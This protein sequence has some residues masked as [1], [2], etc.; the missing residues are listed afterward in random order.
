MDHPRAIPQKQPGMYAV[1][2][3]PIGGILPVDKP[4]QLYELLKDVPG[5]EIRIAPHETLYVINLTAAEAERV[6]A[7][8]EDG[9]S[10]EFECSVACI[11]AATCQQGVRGTWQ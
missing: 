5:A 4:R 8:T 9:A 6:I 2:Y 10:T 1:K 11:G 7:A 3:H